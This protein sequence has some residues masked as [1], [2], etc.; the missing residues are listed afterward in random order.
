[1]SGKPTV[2][3]V[4]AFLPH[5]GT[6]MAYHLGRILHLH[7]N[8]DVVVL[9]SS[10][11]PAHESFVY[12]T[13]FETRPIDEADRL[14]GADDIFICN[15]SFSNHNFGL[16]LKGRKLMYVQGFSTFRQ[17]DGFFDRYVAVSPFVRDFVRNV[18]GI[19]TGLIAPF[20][21]GQPEA[22][23]PPWLEREPLSLALWLKEGD[24]DAKSLLLNR[25]RGHL[26]SLD[27]DL[28]AR[29]PW[30][31][32]LAAATIRRSHKEMLRFLGTKRY[33][34]TLSVCEGFGLVP[35]ETMR[36]GAC[37]MGLD[38][39]GGRAY[40]GAHNGRF[41]AYPRLG[42]LARQM[43]EALTDDALAMR[44]ADAGQA[45][46]REYTYERFVTAWIEEFHRFGL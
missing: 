12:D 42:D 10:A 4:E 45:T 27:A 24:F 40:M 15:P 43:A 2:Y 25:L 7:F 3:I 28:E 11:E 34:L 20:L 5:G 18:Y 21:P 17:L 23:A 29:I 16:R 31:D 41:T 26:K 6:Y 39:F 8:L 38:G 44:L 19:E 33:A 22:E 30:D 1:M 35:L 32:A 36:M 37:V 14:V 13:P 46:A 9:G